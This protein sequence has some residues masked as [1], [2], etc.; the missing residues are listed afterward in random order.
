MLR[1]N[2]RAMANPQGE[3]GD[4][5]VFDLARHPDGFFM[6]VTSGQPGRGPFAFHRLG[7]E[8]P[9]WIFKKMSNGHSLTL[10]PEGR[11]VVVSTTNRR[12]QGNGVVRDKDGKYLGNF[13]PI[14]VFELPETFG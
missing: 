3:S 10:H 7:E 1:A 14:H 8:K 11:H 13:S 5:F 9:F 4:G 2:C 6:T 12:S